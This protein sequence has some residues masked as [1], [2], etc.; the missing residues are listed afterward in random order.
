MQQYN[1][2]D[3]IEC[4]NAFQI[5]NAALKPDARLVQDTRSSVHV[6]GRITPLATQSVAITRHLTRHTLVVMC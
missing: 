6:R 5:P 4:C 1:Y 3:N 2:T